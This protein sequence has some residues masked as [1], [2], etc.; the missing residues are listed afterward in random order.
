MTSAVLILVVEE[1]G[2]GGENLARN[3]SME[4]YCVVRARGT[5]EALALIEQDRPDL[6]VAADVAGERLVGS[7][8]GAAAH[9]DCPIVAVGKHEP[10]P[11]SRFVRR[12]LRRPLD[13][14]QLLSAIRALCESP[15]QPAETD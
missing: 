2:D 6:I 14:S 11:P 9:A 1:H 8:E 13:P 7:L 3:I 4:G 5:R 15:E 12:F 10:V